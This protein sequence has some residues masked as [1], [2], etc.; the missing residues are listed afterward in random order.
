[1]LV[2]QNLG[3]RQPEANLSFFGL[4]RFNIEKGINKKS[5]ITFHLLPLLMTAYLINTC[6]VSTIQLSKTIIYK[7]FTLCKCTIFRGQKSLK[8]PT[9]PLIQ[10]VKLCFNADVDLNFLMRQALDRV[11]FLPFGYLMDQWRWSVFSGETTKDSY[12][13]KWWDLRSGSC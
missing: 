3:S 9:S 8:H 7:T 5:V 12:N 13:R 10:S 4:A 1:M 2:G 11:A 6:V